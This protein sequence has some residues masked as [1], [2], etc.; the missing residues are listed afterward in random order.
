MNQQ[1]FW[2]WTDY[3]INLLNGFGLLVEQKNG[4]KD[5]TSYNACFYNFF[6]IFCCFLDD[7]KT[8]DDLSI[9]P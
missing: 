4:L 9:S 1:Q 8:A 7:Y 6:T 2:Q 5:D 3:V